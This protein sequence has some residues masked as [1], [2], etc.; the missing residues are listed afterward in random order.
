M[1]DPSLIIALLLALCWVRNGRVCLTDPFSP[2]SFADLA[3]HSGPSSANVFVRLR[4]SRCLA[5]PLFML[6]FPF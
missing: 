3:Q 6:A 1:F 4:E 5:N 2:F